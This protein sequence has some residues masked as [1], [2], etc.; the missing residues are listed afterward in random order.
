MLNSILASQNF[1]AY[2]RSLPHICLSAYS[3]KKAIFLSKKG[4][5]GRVCGLDRQPLRGKPLK[6]PLIAE[7]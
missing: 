1:D 7:I 6:N 4:T 2:G 5:R 3:G